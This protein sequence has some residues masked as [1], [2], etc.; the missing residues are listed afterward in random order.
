MKLIKSPAA[1]IFTVLSLFISFGFILF[2]T[3]FAHIGFPLSFANSLGSID[4]M[5]IKF[6]IFE[7]YLFITCLIGLFY[8]RWSLFK[9]RLSDIC[10]ILILFILFFSSVRLLQT[11]RPNIIFAVRNAAFCWYLILPLL[12]SF[13]PFVSESVEFISVASLLLCFLHF[14]VSILRVMVNLDRQLTLLVFIGIYPFFY[15]AFT[16]SRKWMARFLLLIMGIYFGFSFLTSFQR[17]MTLGMIVVLIGLFTFS[18][19][20]KI[21]RVVILKRLVICAFFSFSAIA[22]YSVSRNYRQCFIDEPAPPNRLICLCQPISNANP[23]FRGEKGATG[24][25]RF[26]TEMWTDAFKIFLEKP[27]FG[28]GFQR[29]V[30]YRTYNGFGEWLDNAKAQFERPPVAGPHNSYLNAI[31][32]LG[33]IGILFLILHL[34]VLYRLVCM[35]SFA[36]AWIVY[37][38]MVYA[39][40]NVGLEGPVRSFIILLAIGSVMARPVK[41]S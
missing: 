9:D 30:V 7:Q 11:L 1:L 6:F 2:Q 26:R 32:R 19:K 17:T 13:I 20:I 39:F 16:T 22:Y 12:I 28:V 25:E 3:D 27:L 33:I 14:N 18:K 40:F 10:T 4:K 37:A 31:A 8:F 5:Q 24:L 23:L 21:S 15:A 34:L 36:T 35:Q 41:K 29:Q 38:Q